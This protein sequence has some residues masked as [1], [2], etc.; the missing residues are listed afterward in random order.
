QPQPESPKLT[1]EWATKVARL[2]AFEKALTDNGMPDS[3]EAA[4]A[5][6]A[7]QAIEVIPQ[8][9][10]AVEK[11]ETDALPEASEKAAEQVYIDTANKLFN[12]LNATLTAYQKSDD[13]RKLQIA[14]AWKAPQP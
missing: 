1:D 13:P 12:G 7:R 10:I 6:L 8:R 3:Y 2:S 14:N 4:H 11:K 9:K 5:R